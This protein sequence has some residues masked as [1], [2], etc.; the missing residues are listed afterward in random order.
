M[1]KH[2][3]LFQEIQKLHKKF[4]RGKFIPCLVHFFMLNQRI[5]SHLPYFVVPTQCKKYLQI[6]DIILAKK[7]QH[8]LYYKIIF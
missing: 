1:N 3:N 4:T 7:I 2:E 6:L 8:F 5:L